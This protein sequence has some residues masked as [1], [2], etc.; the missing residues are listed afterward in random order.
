M[1]RQHEE[2][3]DEQGR[4]ERFKDLS[5]AN[6]VGSSRWHR[7]FGELYVLG[8]RSGL[9]TGFGEEYARVVA[10]FLSMRHC[11]SPNQALQRNA[12]DHVHPF[13]PCL[14]VRRG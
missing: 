7:S 6:V 12:Y 8:L 5:F 11:T 1:Y 9:A 13:N 4:R 14:P 3:R 2:F 10:E